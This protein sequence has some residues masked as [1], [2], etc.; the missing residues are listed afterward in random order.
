MTLDTSVKTEATHLNSPKCYIGLAQWNHSAW[1]DGPLAGNI[2]RHALGRYSRY[3][4]TVEGNTTFYGLPEAHTVQEWYQQ[5]PEDFRFCFKL[6]KIITHE[7]SLRHCETELNEAIHRLSA[8]QE[9]LGLLCIQLPDSFSPDEMDILEQFLRGLPKE[10]NYGIEVR[11]L[12]FYQKDD[13]E[14]RFNALL[15]E[16]GIN[17]IQF[18][19]RALFNNPTHDE[20]TQDALSVKPKVP[21]HVIATGQMPMVRFITARDWQSTL[22]YLDPWINKISQWLHEGRSPFVFL[23]TPSNTHAPEVAEH[24]AEQLNKRIADSAL[25]STWPKPQKDQSSL[26]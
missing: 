24:F 5:T 22:N 13:T 21:L 20:A 2:P 16:Q 12:G 17:R 7:L 11:H 4:S 8:L 9:K 18:D 15:M 23:H 6:P 1:N 26:F 25:F 14:R 19:T 3:F 10:L